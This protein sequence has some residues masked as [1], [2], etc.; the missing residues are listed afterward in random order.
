[1]ITERF[2]NGSRMSRVI[3]NDNTIYFAGMTADRTI[4]QS[5]G[6]QTQE[7]LDRLDKRL[8]EF[9]SHKSK[10]LQAIIWLS[11]VRHAEEFNKV[12]DGWVVPGEAPVR[13]C[14]EA[15]L[16][17]PKKYIEIIAVATR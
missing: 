9:G 1:M 6:E 10:L 7:I 5:V 11:D 3:V 2:E 14:A 15:R 13:A 17:D 16:Q 8:S 4:G 12:W